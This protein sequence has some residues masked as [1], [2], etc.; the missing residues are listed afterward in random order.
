M[1]E[2]AARNADQLGYWGIVFPDQYMWDP[3]DLGVDSY[4]GIDST[5][6]TWIL[7][8]DLAAKT[9]N[10]R[11]GTW[12]TPVPLRP[13][14]MLAKIVSTVDLLSSGRVILGVGAGATRRMFEAYSQWDTPRVR[15]DKTGE[16]VELILRLWTEKK[17]DYKGHYYNTK[18]AVLDPKPIQKPHPPLLF[19]GGGRRMLRL[20]GRCA[21]ICYV[22]PWN[23]MDAKEAREIVLTEAK[24]YNRQNQIRFAYAYTPLGPSQHYSREHYGKHVEE[25]AKNGYDYFITAFNMDA[26]PWEV[27]AST[28]KAIENYLHSLRDFAANVMSSYDK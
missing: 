3:S 13:P 15:V 12:V 22:P 19:G 24:R 26:A 9:T 1:V 11:L 16:G 25:A 10:I 14:A 4:Q 17:V 23:K 28:P 6:E 27:E 8:T 7:L 2:A 18:G 5:L 20:A 21:D